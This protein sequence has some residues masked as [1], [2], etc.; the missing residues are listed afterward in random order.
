M[1]A[2]NFLTGLLALHHISFL[3]FCI[4]ISVPHNVIVGS[5]TVRDTVTTNVVMN[6]LHNYRLYSC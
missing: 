3:L 4:F 2:M 5:I 6:P 1:Q